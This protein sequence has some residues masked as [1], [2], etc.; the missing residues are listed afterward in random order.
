MTC[1]NNQI[2]EPD[3]VELYGELDHFIYWFL[4]PCPLVLKIER[5]SYY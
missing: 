3:K 4:D 5:K 1:V 2:I